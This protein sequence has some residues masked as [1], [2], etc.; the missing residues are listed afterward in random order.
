MMWRCDNERFG[1]FVISGVLVTKAV[2][3]VGGCWERGGYIHISHSI[4]VW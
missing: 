2:A 4:M 3:G 1:E